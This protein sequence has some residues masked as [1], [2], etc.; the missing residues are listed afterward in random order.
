[1][2]I[3]R[4]G[5]VA[6]EVSRHGGLAICAPIAPFAAVRAQVR[7]E[8]EDAGGELILVHVATPLAECERRDRKGLYA[9]ARRGELPEFTGISSPYEP[10]DDAD[11]RLDTT[12]RA[13][14]DCVEEVWQLLVARGHLS[15]LDSDRPIPEDVSGRAPGP[16]VPIGH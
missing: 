11:L 8:V 15:D 9:R 14:P 3:R 1:L 2:N 16:S 12:D 7:A 5:F 4:I 6:A 13:V 10:P